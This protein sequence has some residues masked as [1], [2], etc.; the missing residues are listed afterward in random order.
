MKV[1]ILDEADETTTPSYG[2]IEEIVEEE[3][4]S[5][6]FIC[7]AAPDPDLS[8]DSQVQYCCQDHK[9]LHF[10]AEQDQPY[11][12]IVKYRPE[13]G[14]YMVA[15]RDI[16]PGE[17]IFAEEFLAVGPNHI[18][19]PC[20]LDCLKESPEGG[21]QCPN[22]NLPVCEEMCAYGEEHTKECQIFANLEDK[23]QVE[24]FSQPHSV[25]WCIT[26]LRVMRLRDE[27]PKKYDIIERMMSHKEAH[28]KNELMH[29]T[30]KEE[31][32]DFLREKCKLKEK[33]SEDDMFHVLGVLDVNSV[34]VSS[35]KGHGLYALT[36][37]LSHSCVS[38]SK[39]V[40]KSD[41]STECKATVFIPKGEEVTKQYVSPLETT[42][43]RRKKLKEGWY[44]DC[45]CSRC[46]D[47]TEYGTLISATRCLRCGEGTILPLDPLNS[48]DEAVWRCDVCMKEAKLEAIHK[49]VSYFLEKVKHPQVSNSVEALEDMLE[50]ATKLLHPN[51][52]IVTLIR[53][54]MNNAYI[55][56]TD[57]MFGEGGDYQDQP[58]PCEVY[59]RR[60]ELLDETHKLIDVLDPGL[61]R[62]RGLSLFETSTCHLQLGRLLYES[63]RFPLEDFIQL[64]SSEIVSLKEAIECLEASREGTNEAIIHYKSECALHEAEVML[65]LLEK[66]KQEKSTAAPSP[67]TSTTSTAASA[68]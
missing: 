3:E 11:P 20:C 61:T 25:Y 57:R 6:C 49:L 27:D 22:C 35:N 8:C 60:K 10:P 29:K 58:I 43:M 32:V 14:R 17:V 46:Q 15:S 62:R 19:L 38:N 56:L 40:L 65:R 54:M 4:I 41:Y 2:R 64:L 12:F 18:T 21:F 31:V 30:Y 9:E 44:F 45:K 47:P 39:S 34:K 5:T 51:H 23:I 55:Q 24:D 50:K 16:N 26:S 66:E 68:I 7:N 36:S 28:A 59:M 48:S 53:V 42:P 33:Y 1:K 63:E 52:Y 37:L 13:V 67:S